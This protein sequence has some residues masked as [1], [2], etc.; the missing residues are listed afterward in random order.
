MRAGRAAHTAIVSA[1]LGSSGALPSPGLLGFGLGR[2]QSPRRIV[3]GRGHD[4]GKGCPR[5]I[6]RNMGKDAG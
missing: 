3:G 1:G 5:T 6:P 2:D 4:A